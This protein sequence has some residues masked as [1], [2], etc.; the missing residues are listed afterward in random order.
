MRRKRVLTRSDCPELDSTFFQDDGTLITLPGVSYDTKARGFL[1]YK[2]QG[3]QRA[4]KMLHPKDFGS[5][6]LDLADF[7]RDS[8]LG[9]VVGPADRPDPESGDRSPTLEEWQARFLDNHPV[10]PVTREMYRDMYKR[11]FRLEVD[12]RRLGEHRVTEVADR[13]VRKVRDILVKAVDERTGRPLSANTINKYLISLN[14]MFASVVDH[15]KSEYDI[16]LVN[17]CVTVPHVRKRDTESAAARRVST[18]F[19]YADQAVRYAEA[20][21]E[22]RRL[23]ARLMEEYAFRHGEVFGVFVKDHTKPRTKG[24]RWP[25]IM[26]RHPLRWSQIDLDL[27]ILYLDES[28]GDDDTAVVHLT[29]EFTSALREFR[30]ESTGEYLFVNR[31]GSPLRTWRRT[32]LRAMRESGV[33]RERQEKNLPQLSTHSLRHTTASLMAM[34][35]ADQQEIKSIMRHKH[36]ATSDTYMHLSP[37]HSRKATRRSESI[38]KRASSSGGN[39]Q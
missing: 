30:K 23:A 28:K 18:R 4:T 37:E 19:L 24:E 6:M 33:E 3:R 25:K 36:I 31:D 35:G 29:P 9:G 38:F 10:R 13:H 32:H 26:Q 14:V 39:N 7:I 21:P 1:A 20:V 22:E 12:G 27:G 34:D 15:W 17:P 5:L 2:G 16:D 8:A 11:L